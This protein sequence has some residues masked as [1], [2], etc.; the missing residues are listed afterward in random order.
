[1]ATVV[2][3][4]FV[5]GR[6]ILTNV[7]RKEL[8]SIAAASSSSTGTDFIKLSIRNTAIGMPNATYGMIRV[9]HWFAKPTL[10]KT[11]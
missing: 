1:M 7:F 6:M 11:T 4:G 10:L 2:R 5:T 3:I 8:P 9:Y